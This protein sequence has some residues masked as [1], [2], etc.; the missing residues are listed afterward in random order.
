MEIKFLPSG[1]YININKN[2]LSE[3]VLNKLKI[4]YDRYIEQG[5]NDNLISI[6]CTILQNFLPVYVVENL[7]LDDNFIDI[8]KGNKKIRKIDKNKNKFLMKLNKNI[9]LV[10]EYIVEISDNKLLEICKL[11]YPNFN[12]KENYFKIECDIFIFLLN[13]YLKD[14]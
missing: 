3:Y 4:E 11:K 2:Q 9:K 12:L 7:Y 8:Y 5:S 6:N 1:L 13:Y 10:M 14:L